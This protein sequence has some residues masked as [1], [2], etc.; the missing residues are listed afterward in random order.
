MLEATVIGPRVV[1]LSD[2]TMLV[3]PGWSATSLPM[4]G[5]VMEKQT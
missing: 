3:G 1:A 2:A 5:W 4:G